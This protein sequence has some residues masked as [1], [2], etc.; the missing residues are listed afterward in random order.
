MTLKPFVVNKITALAKGLAADSHMVSQD[1]LVTFSAEVSSIAVPLRIPSSDDS[2]PKQRL[3]VIPLCLRS[4][5]CKANISEGLSSNELG[6]LSAACYEC[7]ESFQWMRLEHVAY[8]AHCAAL[9]AWPELGPCTSSPVVDALARVDACAQHCPS[10]LCKTLH[11]LDTCGRDA[12]AILLSRMVGA[13]ARVALAPDR[14]WF[15]HWLVERIHEGY[16]EESGYVDTSLFFRTF[17]ARPLG[18]S[19]IELEVDGDC[20]DFE[21]LFFQAHQCLEM[22]VQTAAEMR[23]AAFLKSPL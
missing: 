12:L 8:V 22:Q 5:A 13:I 17:I 7:Y 21:R 6:M 9:V 20:C 11:S 4:S 16:L 15:G 10:A 19:N 14:S 1:R 2:T 18:L 23:A 3:S